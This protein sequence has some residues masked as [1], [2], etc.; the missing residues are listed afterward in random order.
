M[1]GRVSDFNCCMRF[2]FVEDHEL[3]YIFKAKRLD[4]FF[5]LPIT[6]C[7]LKKKMFGPQKWPMI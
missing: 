1:L 3:N 5:Q 7:Y 6:I 4:R 2:E